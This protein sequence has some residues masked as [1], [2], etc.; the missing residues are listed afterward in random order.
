MECIMCKKPIV[1]KPW[2]TIQCGENDMVHGCSYICTKNIDTVV[3]RRYWDRVVNKEDFPG[4]RPVFQETTTSF[5]DN[6]EDLVD[7]IEEEEERE[8]WEYGESSSEEPDDWENS[9]Y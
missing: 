1:G 5:T 4:P 6:P 3:G 2:I 7:D 8:Y 9:E